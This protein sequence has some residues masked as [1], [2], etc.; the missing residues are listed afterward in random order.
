[1][2]RGVREGR[3]KALVRAE[4]RQAASVIEVQVSDD[5]MADVV[6]ADPDIRQGILNRPWLHRVHRA[7]FLGPLSAIADLDD[8]T[9]A[10]ALEQQAVRLQSNPIPFVGRRG[11]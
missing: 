6:G 5:H 11:A 8:D 1:M 2:D 3:Q 9:L 10:I 7:L 4:I